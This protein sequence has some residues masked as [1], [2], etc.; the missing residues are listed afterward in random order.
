M[1]FFVQKKITGFCR[2]VIVW[3][4]NHTADVSKRHYSEDM[5]AIFFCILKIF[6]SLSS[7][8][9]FFVSPSADLIF[10][11]GIFGVVHLPE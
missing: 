9:R 8:L 4:I 3:T 1:L 7:A 10:R 11:I 6:W 2:V 5:K